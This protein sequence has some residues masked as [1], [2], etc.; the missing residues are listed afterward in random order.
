MEI[1]S[2]LPQKA[3]PGL[4][5]AR[6]GSTGVMGVIGGPMNVGDPE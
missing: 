2:F 6:N 3:T 5:G 4:L 1:R